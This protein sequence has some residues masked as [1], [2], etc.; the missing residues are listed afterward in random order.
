MKAIQK[1]NLKN[2]LKE[3]KMVA[4]VYD[5]YDYIKIETMC[6]VKYCNE[7]LV[8]YAKDVENGILITD[9]NGTYEDA[10]LNGFSEKELNIVA[11]N[12]GLMF[13]GE[14]IFAIVNPGDVE[15]VIEKFC[16][17]IQDLNI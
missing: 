10:L 12:N 8:L 1:T 11:Q 14:S 17:V 16:R 7:F 6:P 3:T 13:N 4:N 2:S 15:Q 5:H 9:L